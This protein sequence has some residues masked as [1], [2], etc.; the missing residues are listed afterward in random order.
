[1][2]KHYKSVLLLGLLMRLGISAQAQDLYV[3]SGASMY[4]GAGGT[5]AA[6]SNVILDNAATVGGTG[7]LLLNGTSAQTID[8]G[9]T[10]TG[11]VIN[12][13]VIN[14]AAGVSLTGNSLRIDSSLTLTAGNLYTADK[15]L[16]LTDTARSHGSA[17]AYIVPASGTGAGYIKQLLSQTYSAGTL[18]SYPTGDTTGTAEYSPIS[19]TL[20][21]GATVAAGAYY[22]LGLVNAD[23]PNRISLHTS[24][25]TRYWP[26]TQSGLSNY[27]ISYLGNYTAADVV[28]TATAIKGSTYSA[29]WVY[30]NGGSATSIVTG[31]VTN[32]S[33]F[34]VF[35]QNI[36]VTVSPKVLLQGAM[37]GTT[38]TT[39]LR[40]NNLIPASQPY[41]TASFSNYNGGEAVAT[42]PTGI[43]DWVLVDLRDATT[44]TTIIA[45]RAGLVKSDGTVTDIDGVSPV[46]FLGA[47]GSGNYYVG[48]RHRNHLA[49]RSSATIAATTTA[50]R[51]Y[52]FTLSQSSAYQ[53]VAITANAAMKDMGNGRF[54]MWGGNANSNSNVRYLGP[55]NDQNFLLNT[56]L[57]GN[58]GL[59]LSNTYSNADLNMNGTTRYL[60]PS[61][62]QNFLLNTVLGGNTGLILTQ[63]L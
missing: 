35:G 13:L 19:F 27:T 50:S 2:K 31:D 53:N 14:N 29:G 9:Y 43:T 38:M 22:Q 47:A 12:T 36:G 25:I 55:S 5:V 45:T 44:P 16:V 24:Y 61:N 33:N 60:G 34:D 57:G 40:N 20:N 15:T 54:A 41:N 23:H 39:T 37:S 63:H 49:I 1:M 51:S 11:P 30:N 46:D 56:T 7:T 26:V 17:T 58:T 52:D 4:I 8:G 6:R 18:Y 3:G 59:I 62:D 42:L 32:L 28:G 48:I 21:G 10:S